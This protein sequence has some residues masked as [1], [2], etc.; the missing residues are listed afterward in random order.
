MDIKISSIRQ[1]GLEKVLH[2][3]YLP[4]SVLQAVIG[5]LIQQLD[6]Q[7]V[8][9]GSMFGLYEDPQ[10]LVRPMCGVSFIVISLS[11]VVPMSISVHCVSHNYLCAVLPI[12]VCCV[13]HDYLHLMC[14]PSL[15]HVLPI[16]IPVSAVLLI[17]V[18]VSGMFQLGRQR[19][20]KVA[21]WIMKVVCCNISVEQKKSC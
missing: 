13:I 19:R 8:F 16:N 1:Q 7:G 17:S 11:A 20:Q 14:Y 5:T 15:S 6:T 3:K 2:T 4:A 21:V 18:S 12:S 10:A 9:T